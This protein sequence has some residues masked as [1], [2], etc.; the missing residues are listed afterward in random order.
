M[1]LFQNSLQHPLNLLIC[2][3]VLKIAEVLRSGAYL[4]YVS[5]LNASKMP[6]QP[7][8]QM[9]LNVKEEVHNIS[10]LHNVLLTLNTNLTHIAASLL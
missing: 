5:I 10:I 7:T 9:F 8:R 1:R 4:T 3:G 6:K 2:E